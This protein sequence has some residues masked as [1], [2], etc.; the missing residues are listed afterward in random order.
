[1]NAC[2]NAHTI[3]STNVSAVN[4]LCERLYVALHKALRKALYE[5][6]PKLCTKLYRSFT[7]SSTKT[8]AYMVNKAYSAQ[9]EF[10]GVFPLS[11]KLYT[12]IIRIK[13]KR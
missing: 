6:L 1:M 11:L 13:S 10:Q 5:A 7:R 4:R 2:I 12:Y 9:G 3:V 8:S